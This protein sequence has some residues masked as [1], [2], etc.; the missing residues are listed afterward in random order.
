MKLW[1][2][3]VWALSMALVGCVDELIDDEETMESRQ[4][5]LELQQLKLDV[6]S[7]PGAK[8]GPHLLALQRAVATHPHSGD[9][10]TRTTSSVATCRR[11]STS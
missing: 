7:G 1:G 6:T 11:I 5:L 2:I 3:S 4:A 8:L 9:A 10:E